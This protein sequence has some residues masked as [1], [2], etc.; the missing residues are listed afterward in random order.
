MRIVEH[1]E[2]YVGEISSAI[3]ITDKKYNVTISLHERTPFDEIR[4]YSTLGLNRYFIDCYFEFIFV[5][6]YNFSKS[7]IASFLTSFSEYLIEQ[8]KS[9][10]QGDVISF[11]FRIISETKMN[12]LYFTLPFY[13]DE[14][15]QQLDLEERSVI[16][17][18]IIPVYYEEA[19]LIREKGWSSFEE[20]LEENAIDNLWD[21]HREPYS[22]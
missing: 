8:G 12:S 15:L 1:I 16:F 20:F 9:V 5:C 10:R 3:N 7:E 6:G 4:T 2:N 21:L 18:L 13:F 14:N 22:W 11:D 19:Q 17:P